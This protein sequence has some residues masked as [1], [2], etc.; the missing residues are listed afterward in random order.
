[1]TDVIPINIRKDRV[2]IERI[3]DELSST[4]IATIK[5]MLIQEGFEVRGQHGGQIHVQNPLESH[6]VYCKRLLPVGYLGVDLDEGQSYFELV[7]IEYTSLS[8]YHDKLRE[9]PLRLGN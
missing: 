9:I 5:E 7:N 6:P 1:M 2:T 4:T 8:R 3:L